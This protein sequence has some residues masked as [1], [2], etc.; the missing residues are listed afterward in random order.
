MELVQQYAM[1]RGKLQ[2]ALKYV[3]PNPYYNRYQVKE[4]N[5]GYNS[6]EVITYPSTLGD[7]RVNQKHNDY[8]TAL[9][10]KKGW[11]EGDYIS[12]N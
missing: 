12:K 5:N 6:Q 3:A 7:I 4:A 9:Q 11:G 8:V 1:V 2:P 10:G